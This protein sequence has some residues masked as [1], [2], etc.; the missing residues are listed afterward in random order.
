MLTL[1]FSDLGLKFCFERVHTLIDGLH[2]EFI[3]KFINFEV[4][5]SKYSYIETLSIFPASQH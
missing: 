2:I 4:S 3:F 5:T 1:V